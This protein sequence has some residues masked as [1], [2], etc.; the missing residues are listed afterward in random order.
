[1]LEN[2]GG[3]AEENCK[4]GAGVWVPLET[5]NRKVC[6]FVKKHSQTRTPAYPAAVSITGSVKPTINEHHTEILCLL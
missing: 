1:M 4:S 3:G 6:K 2:K 5:G